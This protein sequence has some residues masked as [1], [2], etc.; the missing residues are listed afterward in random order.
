MKACDGQAQRIFLTFRPDYFQV[1]I[2]VQQ[3]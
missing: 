1:I 3:F 2:L